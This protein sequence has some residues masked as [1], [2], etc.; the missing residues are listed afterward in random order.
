[1]KERIIL[2]STFNSNALP[3]NLIMIF[4]SPRFSASISFFF[5]LKRKFIRALPMGMFS[6]SAHAQSFGNCGW[7][8]T[9]FFRA[10]AF[11]PKS[12]SI[13]GS[14]DVG[15]VSWVVPTGGLS[16]ASRVLNTPG[17]SWPTTATSGMSIGHKGML[18]AAKVLC[19][20]ALELLSKP[21]LVTAAKR[22]LAR[23]TAQRTY[24]SPLPEGQ[25][26]PER[27]D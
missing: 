22:E 13:V 1:M 2:P 25:P 27:L 12:P 3:F 26:P 11:M 23:H 14:T 21:E 9:S 16:V 20:T 18:T 5:K 8:M 15:D 7:I 17:H 4:F 10:L 24:R 19:A 6:I